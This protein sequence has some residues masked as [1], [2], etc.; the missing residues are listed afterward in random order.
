V[1]ETTAPRIGN[2][3]RD[4][5]TDEAREV[6]AF[7]G[8]PNAWEQGSKTNMTMTLANHPKL[9]MAYN[10]FGKH[11]LLDSAIAVRPRELIVLRTA[12]L[13]RSEYEWHYHVGYALN[14]GMTLAEIAAVGEGPSSPVWHDKEVDRAVL[15]AVDELY[16]HSRISD[17]TWEVLSR[18][19]D[20]HQMME[21]VFTIGNYVLLS[22]VV[23]ALGIPLEAGADQI[24]FDLKTRSGKSPEARFR[25]G[26]SD[27][28]AEKQFVS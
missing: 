4:E 15:S 21:L 2:L 7:W 24:G 13:T 6:F 11:L 17:A 20:R 9:A 3:P 12:W 27:D 25:P 10:T 1:N 14:A 26:E 22:W 19:F 8:E 16:R 18:C 5:W 23:A 28:W